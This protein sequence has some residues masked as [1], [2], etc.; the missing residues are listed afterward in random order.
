MSKEKDLADLIA[1][2]YEEAVSTAY[3]LGEDISQHAA[4]NGFKITDVNDEDVISLV[5]AQLKISVAQYLEDARERE[6]EDDAT[7]MIKHLAAYEK[8]H[9]A[10]LDEIAALLKVDDEEAQS[11]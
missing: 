9:F 4:E 6:T 1:C 3:W 2:S 7:L 5:I 10:K 8:V 11:E